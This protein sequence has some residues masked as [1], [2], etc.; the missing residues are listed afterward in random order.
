MPVLA[1]TD[2][3]VCGGGP[4]GCAAGVGAALS[5]D[6]GVA[7]RELDSQRLIEQLEKGRDV[8]RLREGS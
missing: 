6:G 7:P 8:E 1:E 4:A 3:V 2:V 5:L